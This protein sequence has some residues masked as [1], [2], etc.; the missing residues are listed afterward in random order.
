MEFWSP[1]KTERKTAS[2]TTSFAAAF[3]S[4]RKEEKAAQAA[5]AA[6]ASSA[7]DAAPDI[8]ARPPA[9]NKDPEATA[10]APEPEREPPLKFEEVRKEQ[11]VAAPAVSLLSSGGPWQVVLAGVSVVLFVLYA[12][13]L[14]EGVRLQDCARFDLGPPPGAPDDGSA[15]DL[16]YVLASDYAVECSGGDYRAAQALAVLCLCVYGALG[17]LAAPVLGRTLWR[18]REQQAAFGFVVAQF[19]EQFR[20]WESIVMLRTLLIVL[21]V[22][23]APGPQ[24]QA[25]ACAGVLGAFLALHAACRPSRSRLVDA[26]EGVALLA[27]VLCLVIAAMWHHLAA[28][29]AAAASAAALAPPPAL[30]VAIPVLL[31]GPALAFAAAVLLPL[32]RPL[33]CCGAVR[34]GSAAEP[35]YVKDRDPDAEIFRKAVPIVPGADAPRPA[36][37]K[38]KAHFRGAR[39]PAVC[40]APAQ[41]RLGLGTPAS[42]RSARLRTGSPR[43]NTGTPRGL[44]AQFNT[45]GRHQL[46]PPDV[47]L[48]SPTSG[49][50]GSAGASLGGSLG[51]SLGGSLWHPDAAEAPRSPYSAGA[52]ALPGQPGRPGAG[53]HAAASGSPGPGSLLKQIFQDVILSDREAAEHHPAEHAVRG[54]PGSRGLVSLA[55][56]GPVPPPPRVPS[57]VRFGPTETVG[58]NTDTSTSCSSPV[59]LQE[60]APDL[61]PVR[62]S[63]VWR[64]PLGS[65]FAGAASPAREAS[66]SPPSWE[67]AVAP[68]EEEEEE[69]REQAPAAPEAPEGAAAAPEGPAAAPPDEDAAP[70]DAAGAPEDHAAA[71]PPDA[72]AA[73]EEVE[74]AALATEQMPAAMEDASPTPV[75]VDASAVSEDASV[76]TEPPAAAASAVRNTP[77]PPAASLETV[78]AAALLSNPPPAPAAASVPVGD[79]APVMDNVSSAVEEAAAAMKDASATPGD[80]ASERKEEVS[81]ATEDASLAPGDASPRDACLAPGGSA[82]T[83]GGASAASGDAALERRDS[84]VITVG[85]VVMKDASAVMKDASAVSDAAA[86]GL[87]GALAASSGATAAPEGAPAAP[88]K[89]DAFLPTF[90]LPFLSKGDAASPSPPR[91]DASPTRA[92]SPPVAVSP[93]MGLADDLAAEPAAPPPADVPPIP[94]PSSPAAAAAPPTAC[95]APSDAPAAMEAAPPGTEDAAR[96]PRK[97]SAFRPT[98]RF[99]FLSKGAATPPALDAASQL[100]T[101]VQE[102]PPLIP[103]SPALELG[104]ALTEGAAPPPPAADSLLPEPSTP[105]LAPLDAFSRPHASPP[106]AS[107]LHPGSLALLLPCDATPQD[108]AALPLDPGHA[109]VP[110]QPIAVNSEPSAAAAVRSALSG[111][112]AAPANPLALPGP[113]KVPAASPP[114]EGARARG[115]PAPEPLNPLLTERFQQMSILR[116]RA[117]AMRSLGLEDEAEAGDGGAPEEPAGTDEP[118]QTDSLSFALATTPNLPGTAA[119]AVLTETLPSDAFRFSFFSQRSSSAARRRGSGAFG[120]S[121]S[122]AL[123]AASPPAPLRQAPGASLAE[124][125]PPRRNSGAA[126]VSPAAAGLGLAAVSPGAMPFH[127][128]GPGLS[129]PA[130]P[131][132]NSGPFLADVVPPRPVSPRAIPRRNSAPGAAVASPPVLLRRPSGVMAASPP[133]PRPVPQYARRTSGPAP[134]S[135]RRNS[136]LVAALPPT[137][138]PGLATASPPAALPTLERGGS[139]VSAASP[140]APVDRRLSWHCIAGLPPLNLFPSEDP[141]D[142]P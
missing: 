96:A 119:D 62:I 32:L 58:T 47:W 74:D 93:A 44:T 120:A 37:A 3:W 21:V 19:K 98:F 86:P 34:R 88:R 133:A 109:L 64:S 87:W 139:G 51:A 131:R 65:S 103:A 17:P 108:P 10:A 136:G 111:R 79:A 135:S 134:Q 128:P 95:P 14:H 11:A 48:T 81:A 90:W 104:S 63:P 5:A 130:L 97:R 15:S 70:D 54:R 124:V 66:P 69:R 142:S 75:M 112:A 35:E 71:A 105:S 141:P 30:E 13:L 18:S 92:A 43:S 106:G 85:S 89:S 16:R 1:N 36:E 121:P 132:P 117:Q 91:M 118:L 125:V 29:A 49:L 23:L 126:A 40:T 100:N 52:A 61:S 122:A 8:E 68:K 123:A 82:S 116:H 24:T 20:Y 42:G 57:A 99:P 102:A 84:S 2:K 55:D 56:L 7:S 115:R 22:A 41:A 137:A 127:P 4:P 59:W 129:P 113:A 67:A 107:P 140:S 60:S 80:A 6:S 110:H 83:L 46:H 76:V 26:L 28:A 39:P 114:Y 77:P 31:S 73:P 50:R 9:T 94:R 138:R 101:P 27:L 72:A 45:S 53:A 25:G 33:V 78:D 12:V 38:S